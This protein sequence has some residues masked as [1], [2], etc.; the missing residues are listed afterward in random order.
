VR[1]HLG[2]SAEDLAAQEAAA[3]PVRDVLERSGT[4]AWFDPFGGRG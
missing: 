1:A 3:A 2:G 4:P